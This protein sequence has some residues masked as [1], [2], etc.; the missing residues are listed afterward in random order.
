M[1]LHEV[2]KRHISQVQAGKELAISPRWVRDLVK[3]LKAQGDRAVVH[4]PRGRASNRRLP[5]AMKARAVKLFAQEVEIE[6]RL[7]QTLW[8]RWRNRRL[9]LDR[10][11]EEKKANYR[12][13]WIPPRAA[14][15]PDAA[16]GNVFASSPANA[17]TKRLPER[18]LWQG[19]A[20]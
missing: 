18:P 14:Q 1:I 8:M 3:R 16:E 17:G 12:A 15:E 6:Q 9:P 11:A 10:C 7:D 2:R 13:P 19:P 20:E 4:R 5:E